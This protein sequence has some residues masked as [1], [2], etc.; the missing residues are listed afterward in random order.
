MESFKKVISGIKG[1]DNNAMKEAATRLDSLI[2]PIGSLG[3]L[4]DIAVQLSGITGKVNN[5]INK[6]CTIIMSADNGIWEE[7]VST[8]PQSLTQMQ[9]LNFTK[10]ICGINVLSNN[11]NMDI[12]IVDIGVNGEVNHPKILNKKIR[13]GTW[14]MCK[15]RAMTEE[16]AIKAIEVGIEMVRDL[17]KEGY[18][19][20]GTGEMG[21]CNTSTS[22][23]IAMAFTGCTSEEAVG[24]GA[25]LTEEGYENKKKAIELSIK[26]NNPDKENPIDV[27]SK[28]GGFDVAG[29]AGCYLGA[30]YYRVPIIIDGFISVAAALVACKLNPLVKGYMIPSHA[31]EEIGYKRIMKELELSPLLN[32]NM[33][34]GEGTGCPLAYNIVT[35]ATRVI[36]DMATFKEAALEDDYLVDIR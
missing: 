20:I 13:N 8:C 34:L 5:E 21:I 1:L 14:N 18:S 36:N 29:L 12:R 35:A 31:S 17:V 10:G 26:V 6:G 30:A 15:G 4:E 16:E 2:K 23:A 7:G 33:R 11:S 28:I 27:L 19:I 3:R 9:T 24:K 25:G 32:L 22:S